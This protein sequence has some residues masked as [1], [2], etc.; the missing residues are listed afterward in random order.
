MLQKLILL[1]TTQN[2]QM[3]PKRQLS[4]ERTACHL[5]LPPEDWEVD[6]VL[7]EKKRKEEEKKRMEE[8]KKRLEEEKKS[9]TFSSLSAS[10][11]SN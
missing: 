10:F 9:R 5:L 6:H 8:E 4:L 1:I 11:T 3:P 2:S 7:S